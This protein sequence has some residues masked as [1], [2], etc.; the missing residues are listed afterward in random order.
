MRTL[1]LGLL[2]G[3][4]GFAGD[5]IRIQSPNF[6]LYTTAGEKK[7]REAIRYFEQVHELFVRLWP[8]AFTETFPARVI[9]FSGEKEFRPY[10]VNEVAAAYYLSDIGRD[11]IVMGSVSSEVFPLVVHEYT[12]LLLK[13]AN[14]NVPLWL[15]EGMADVNSTLQQDGDKIVLGDA[16]PGRMIEL[17][18]GK[19]LPLAR[20]LAIDHNSP[21]YNEKKRAGMFY[22][23]SWL[24]THMLYLSNEYRPKFGE[25][26]L[27][28]ANGT[29]AETAF[30]DT[31]GKS[32]ADV[33]KDLKGYLTGKSINVMK[34]EAKL[35]KPEELPKAV[36]PPEVDVQVN[37]A[38]LL[39][40]TGHMDDGERI[41]QDLARRYPNQWQVEEGLA[42]LSRL[43]RDAM[44]ARMHYAK[45]FQYGEDNPDVLFSY[46]QLLQGDVSQDAEVVAALRKALERRPSFWDAKLLLGLTLYNS[47]KYAEAISELAAIRRVSPER[48]SVLFLALAQSYARIDRPAAA[49]DAV[50][51]AKTYA[52]TEFERQA[53][54][55]VLEAL[56]RPKETQNT[57]SAPV[58]EFER[59]T[60]AALQPIQPN[61]KLRTAVGRMKRVEC[62]GQTARLMIATE[63]GEISL[64]IRDPNA[65]L[66]RNSGGNSAELS[67]GSAP[68][69][70]VSVRYIEESIADSKTAGYIREIEFR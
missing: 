22:A 16:Y 54:D 14:F 32:V 5:W 7:G 60:S 12:H 69:T 23:Q 28:M 67:C 11:Y 10:R 62:L 33:E 34:L 3:I 38:A 2:L 6:E 19:W 59:P 4:C 45:A 9:G 51:K 35:W 52:R 37:L 30:R 58:A 66:I 53:A 26:S 50:Q 46:A 31:W 56:D 42:T 8:G 40:R 15:N 61:Q 63:S 39:N 47:G 55:Q 57:P 29:A 44:G 64:L 65:V 49:R 20:L 48:A 41:L 17:R 70:P 18:N 43:K 27:K 24:L 25:F 13:H 36:P 1:A 68:N 21:E